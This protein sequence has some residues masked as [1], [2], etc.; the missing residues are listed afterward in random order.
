VNCAIL[1][2]SLFMAERS[3]GFG[4]SIVFGFGSGLGWALAIVVLAAI[5][6]RLAYADMP[7]GLR[8]LG[9]TF[10]VTGLMSM[11]FTAFATM[12]AP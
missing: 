5:R 7:A 2:G 4:E 10:I 11:A 3:Y 1:G 9:M 8:G 6:E 12:A